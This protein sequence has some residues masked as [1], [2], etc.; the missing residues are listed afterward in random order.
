MSQDEELSQDPVELSQD[1]HVVGPLSQD[2]V[3]LSQEDHVVGPLSQ[4]P[5]ELSQDA[6]VVGLV[7]PEQG[8]MAVGTL[9][10]TD[11]SGPEGRFSGS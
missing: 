9:F 5:V 4:D 2:P 1:A 6:H 3:E 8:R 7:P 11:R 10:G